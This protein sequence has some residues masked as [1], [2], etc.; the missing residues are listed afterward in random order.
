MTFLLFD[1]W[2]NTSKNLQ[3]Y[4]FRSSFETEKQQFYLSGNNIYLRGRDVYIKS[5]SKRFFNVFAYFRMIVLEEKARSL[6]TNTEN[7]TQHSKKLNKMFHDS[8]PEVLCPSYV[9]LFKFPLYLQKRQPAT[10]ILL[11]ILQLIWNRV[12]ETIIRYW[13]LLRWNIKRV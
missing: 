10:L 7:T 3:R 9:K 12:A 11:L 4:N 8:G 2:C 5:I 1:V 13:L 6:P